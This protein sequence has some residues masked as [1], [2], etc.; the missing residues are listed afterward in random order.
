MT[1]VFSRWFRKSS[2][3]E[4]DLW[5]A[6][7][8]MS[9][10]LIDARLG[11]HLYKKRVASLSRGKRGGA[12]LV[13]ASNLGDRWFFLFGFEKNKR[14]DVS[15]RE[16]AVLRKEAAILLGFEADELAWQKTV[17]NITEIGH[18]A[19]PHTQ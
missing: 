4:R 16:L 7:K 14:A 1:K 2:L 13:I 19:K 5:I 9:C 8:E 10:G 12:R 17:E 11:G 18:E 3:T 15:D 6:I